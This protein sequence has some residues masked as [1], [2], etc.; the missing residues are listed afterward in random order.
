MWTIQI[1]KVTFVVDY[2]GSVLFLLD[3]VVSKRMSTRI[4]TSDL[5]TVFATMMLTTLFRDTN[6][7]QAVD[8]GFE[9]WNCAVLDFLLQSEIRKGKG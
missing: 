1:N 4:F 3:F 6:F 7:M 9:R 8:A 5:V 2:F